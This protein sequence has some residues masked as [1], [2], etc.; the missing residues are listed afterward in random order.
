MAITNFTD[1]GRDG[2]KKNLFV[3]AFSTMDDASFEDVY[4][5]LAPVLARQFVNYPDTPINPITTAFMGEAL[6][7]GTVIQD[8]FVNATPMKATKTSLA[9]LG[10]ATDE[11]G[12]ADVGMLVN[13][14][15]LNTANTSKVSKFEYELRKASMDVNVAGTLGDSILES[16]RVGA[17]AGLENQANKVLVSSIPTSNAVYTEYDSATDDA[18]VKVKKMRKTIVD[19]ALDMTKVNDHYVQGVTEN[20]V[21]TK[22]ADGKANEVYV[23]APKETWADMTMDLSGIYHPELLMFDEFKKMGVNITPI[24]IDDFQTPVTSTEASTYAT[25][26]GV[27]WTSAPG[28]GADK[29]DFIICDKRYFRINPYIDRYVM[30]STPVNAN[31]PYVNFFLHMQN[32]ISY[33]PQRKAAVIY[34]TTTPSP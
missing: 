6:E 18:S 7:Y 15:T 31:L 17:V 16:L 11:L 8:I 12:F 10:D 2:T 25:D 21:T 3:N 22:Y 33:Q 9:T 24:M 30:K 20:N 23:I 27:T 4:G 34:N 5:K 28:I 19:V 13:Y 26:S 29:P 1:N 14:A 32:A